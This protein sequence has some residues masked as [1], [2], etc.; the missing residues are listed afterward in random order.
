MSTS[1]ELD[2]VTRITAGA[3]GEPGSRIFYL[4]AR[5][6]EQLVTLLVE[7]EQVRALAVSIDQM[8]EAL[9]DPAGPQDEDDPTN[10]EL[11]EPLLPEWRVGPMAL[12]YDADRDRIQV[13]ASELVPEDEERAGEPSSARFVATRAQARALAGHAVIVVEAG[14]PP[15]RFCGFPMDASGHVCPAM[16]GHREAGAS[17]D[18]G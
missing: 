11:E 12:H 18:D 3:Q 16:N 1:F 7:K 10:L 8:L 15:C 5:A 13:I 6:G 14:R 17:V 9:P 2:P 4:Q